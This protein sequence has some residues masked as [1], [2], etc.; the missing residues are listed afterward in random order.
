MQSWADSF[1]FLRSRSD[2]F[3]S[4]KSNLWKKNKTSL[5]HVQLLS[6]I[7]CGSSAIFEH[8]NV[9]TMHFLFI[10]K[11]LVAKRGGEI[12]GNHYLP[13]G[14]QKFILD[15]QL[16][17]VLKSEFRT[18]KMYSILGGG[19]S[20]ESK[21]ARTV[22]EGYVSRRRA[23]PARISVC[24]C[25]M[26]LGGYFKHFP[27]QQLSALLQIPSGSDCPHENLFKIGLNSNTRQSS[28]AMRDSHYYYYIILL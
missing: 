21:T 28:S 18:L 16:A 2:S 14:E 12:F 23:A 27:L 19:G 26:T 10:F 3:I 24:A 8:K 9:H 5:I 7:R 15:C 1:L 25:L 6:G 22:E 11:L 17:P 20:P 13:S 4:P